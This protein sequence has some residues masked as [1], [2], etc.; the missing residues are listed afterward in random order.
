[1]DDFAALLLLQMKR[2]WRTRHLVIWF[3]V[4]VEPISAI[5]VLPEMKR[6]ADFLCRK[7]KIGSSESSMQRVWRNHLKHQEGLPILVVK[8]HIKSMCQ[9]LRGRQDLLIWENY[10]LLPSN[11]SLAGWFLMHQMGGLLVM[12]L[13][14][15][16]RRRRQR[17]LFKLW[18]GRYAHI[19]D[20]HICL[21]DQVLIISVQGLLSYIS[22][23]S[24]YAIFMVLG[25]ILSIC[26]V[27]VLS[28]YKLS[29]TGCLDPNI[30]AS[31][32]DEATWLRGIV[33]F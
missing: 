26:G 24:L 6:S 22:V 11:R 16:P 8:P 21:F 33:S 32:V 31:Q 14:H 4:V 10:F 15:L 19:L 1:M 20:F 9:I 28:N 3:W 13:F 23:P 18:M 5:N 27:I 29:I 2:L 25:F 12:G 7:Y 30:L 17:L